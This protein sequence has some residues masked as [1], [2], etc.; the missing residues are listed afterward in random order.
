MAG[1]QARLYDAIGLYGVASRQREMIDGWR[2][3]G[4]RMT[5]L[6]GMHESGSGPYETPT[7]EIWAT[8]ELCGAGLHTEEVADQRGVD[9][10]TVRQHVARARAVLGTGS[11]LATVVR[12]VQRGLIMPPPCRP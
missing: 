11:K 2:P 4:K 3:A 9:P 5:S 12:A 8:L 10:D 6:G 7:S 1:E